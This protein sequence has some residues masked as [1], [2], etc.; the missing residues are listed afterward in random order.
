MVGWWVHVRAHTVQPNA[1][2]MGYTAIPMHGIRI[3]IHACIHVL[4]YIHYI[5]TQT[6]TN[7]IDNIIHTRIHTHARTHVLE[8]EPIGD[9]ALVVLLLA[10]VGA[11]VDDVVAQGHLDLCGVGCLW[12]EGGI[13]FTLRNEVIHHTKATILPNLR[14][15]E[16]ER[17]SFPP[18][19]N[20]RTM[21]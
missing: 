10:L 7:N 12:G 13:W 15:T 17:P 1:A 3:I 14:K 11:V 21:V 9:A 20:K 16:Q 2:H 18:R 4:V 5:H 8:L 6:H 19:I